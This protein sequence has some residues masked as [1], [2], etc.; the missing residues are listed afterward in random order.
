MIKVASVINPNGKITEFY[1]EKVHTGC[2]NGWWVK[3]E[4]LQGATGY[5]QYPK[6]YKSVETLVRSI[7][8]Y[9]GKDK[10]RN[11]YTE[12]PYGPFMQV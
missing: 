6:P 5:G 3:I 12:Y 1:A 7:R 10:E 8:K 11:G 9:W 4:K 2:G